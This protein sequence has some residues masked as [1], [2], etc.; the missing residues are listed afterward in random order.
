[1]GKI[2]VK[3][4]AP[5]KTRKNKKERGIGG[6]GEGDKGLIWVGNISEFFAEVRNL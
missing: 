3:C 5:L 4:L 2:T 1:M 6:G